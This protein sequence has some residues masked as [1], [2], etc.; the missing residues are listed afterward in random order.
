LGR[1]RLF[2][3]NQEE[4]SAWRQTPTRPPPFAPPSSD[5]GQVHAARLWTGSM[6]RT[7]R[8]TRKSIVVTSLWRGGG[9]AGLTLALA[10][11]RRGYEMRSPMQARR[12]AR[13]GLNR[14]RRIAGR[15]SLR[16]ASGASSR[17]WGLRTEAARRGRAGDA[18]RG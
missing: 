16:M 1:A 14:S 18:G 15:S 4:R 2:E 17:R 11:A 3:Q 8:K 10:L 12:R 13:G 6:S 7:W 9:P 5:T